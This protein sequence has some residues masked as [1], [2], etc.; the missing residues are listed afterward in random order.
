MTMVAA[1]RC[2]RATGP[3]IGLG[4]SSYR[5]TRR[6]P[7]PAC[8]RG[9]P[10]P[11]MW[12]ASSRRA[13]RRP[14]AGSGAIWRLLEAATLAAEGAHGGLPTPAEL[15]PDLHHARALRAPASPLRR[16]PAGAPAQRLF[17]D[18][19]SAAEGSKQSP[20]V[21]KHDESLQKSPMPLKKVAKPAAHRSDQALP[22]S[23]GARC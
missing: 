19:F 3:G 8:R 15:R 7:W 23:N 9:S 6:G 1:V 18:F 14:R 11:S 17:G 12:A 22:E 13:A 2:C 21:S 16:A 5:R 20:K 4:P 10:S